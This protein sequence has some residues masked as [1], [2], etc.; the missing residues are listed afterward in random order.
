ML[1]R[2]EK[3]L[4]INSISPC[5]C[6]VASRSANVSLSCLY[7][8]AEK[9]KGVTL[10]AFDQSKGV[11]TSFEAFVIEEGEVLLDAVKLNSMIKS[12]PEGMVTI[13]CDANFVTSISA[14]QA[15]FEILGMSVTSFP[16]LPQLSGEKKFT[17]KQ[18]ILKKMIQQVI[19]SAAVNELKPV[20]TGVLFE[21]KGDQL[22]LCACDGYRI[23]IRDE[24]CISG[25]NMDVKFIVPARSL[26]EII[27]LLEDDEKSEI[28][29]ELAGRHI[30]FIFD[31]FIFFSRYVDGEYIDYKK[32]L[33]TTSKTIVHLELSDAVDCLERCSLLIDERAKSPI[34]ISIEDNSI[35]VKCTTANGK[36]DESF[37]CDV[38]GE[39]MVIGFNNKF[40]LDA[41]KGAYL[42]GDSEVVFELNSPF[43]GMT[44]H[45]TEKNNY[46]YMVVPM[47]L[48]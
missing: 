25:L 41:L 5:L 29:I 47:R 14:G 27:R 39:Q 17:I 18:N 45:S 36:I 34:K 20:L 10:T 30:I 7:I 40:L 21:T 23:A 9:D 11:K 3:N 42:C 37:V 38:K 26:Q 48:Q 31:E 15:K 44:I 19:F 22:R 24:K 12:L 28:R 2:A 13:S 33:P 35:N 46:F 8:K 32:S 1:I 6:A 43:L 16:S 4:L